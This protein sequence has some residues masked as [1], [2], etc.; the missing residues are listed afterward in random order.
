MPDGVGPGG[1]IVSA[2]ASSGMSV[3][4]LARSTR[5]RIGL[6]EQMTDDDFAAT[7]GDVYARGHLR[8]IAGVL[9]LDVDE[10]LAAYAALSASQRPPAP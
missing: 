1:L 2:M 10:L 7:G 9:D 5:L 6:L 3:E 8:V 4:D